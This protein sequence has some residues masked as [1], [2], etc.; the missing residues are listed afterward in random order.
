MEKYKN[1]LKKVFPNFELISKTKGVNPKVIVKSKLGVLYNVQ[2]G[3]LIQGKYP[4]IRSA[5]DKTDC[6]IKLAN[7][8]HNN[9]Y[10]YNKSIYKSCNKPIII[11]CKEHGDFEQLPERHLFGNG[12]VSCA[13]IEVNKKL[14]HSW[15]WENRC[16]SKG[17]SEGYFYILKC[18]F[19]NEEFYKIGVTIDIKK[20][21]PSKGHIPYNYELIIYYKGKVSDVAQIERDFK[22]YNKNLLYKPA[23]KFNGYRECYGLNLDSF[24]KNYFE[25]KE[26]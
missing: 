18:K 24:I 12:C 21:Y 8:K 6:F 10:L 14:N 9:K 19:N 15:K 16:K 2:A 3:N 4:S 5:I 26:R 1:K 17:I 25:D 7:K 11:T 23:I 20:R 13:R 22:S